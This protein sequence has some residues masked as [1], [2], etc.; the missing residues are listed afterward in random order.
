[1]YTNL[2]PRPRLLFTT[3]ASRSHYE[4]V[5]TGLNPAPFP[6]STPPNVA[7]ARLTLFGAGSNPSA[8]IAHLSALVKPGRWIQISEE[9]M[10]FPP[11][12]VGD[13]RT[14]AAVG[15]ERHLGRTLR[16]M[17]EA[18]GF[19]DI[20]EEDVVFNIGRTNKDE[21]LAREGAGI[22]SIAVQGLSRFMQERKRVIQKL[23]TAIEADDTESIREL[24]KSESLNP[25][26]A[27][28]LLYLPVSK[29]C[30]ASTQC[31]LELGADP[32]EGIPQGLFSA[33]RCNRDHLVE[34]LQL[35]AD[36]GLD[37][38]NPKLSILY[39]VLDDRKAVD[40]L[41]DHGADPNAPED[42]THPCIL[43][44]GIEDKTVAAL[45]RA[46]AMCDVA[47]FD[48]LVARGADPARSRALHTAVVGNDHA[49]SAAMVAHLL[50]Q[51]SCFDVNAEDHSG[52]GFAFALE[53]YSLRPL[54]WAIARGN[55]PA[56]EVLVKH[57]ADV[58][59]AVPSALRRAR[60]V[61]GARRLEML[62]YLLDN[63]VDPDRAVEHAIWV[64]DLGAAKM[65]FEFG[66]DPSAAKQHK[67]AWDESRGND[68]SPSMLRLCTRWE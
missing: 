13:E 41:L 48:H 56:A 67:S 66:A 2:A 40:W 22:C 24:F 19:T 21:R 35:L 4:F 59:D 63:G 47:L 1:M 61:K 10:D 7:F 52:G 37:V 44:P 58:G 12:V 17:L 65:C 31:L 5:G 57:G 62:K 68:I 60:K 32:K 46:A 3:P 8:S 14:P 51:Y 54:R 20:G 33:S 42:V 23:R 27:T 36:F 11:D 16:V 9:T 15:V 29:G 38:K 18:A 55:V 53:D 26:D 45:N 50:E 43:P 39:S 6:S 28:R 25:E 49:A 34:M 64:N 30:L